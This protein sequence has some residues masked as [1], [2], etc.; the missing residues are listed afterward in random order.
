MIPFLGM[1]A[2]QFAVSIMGCMETGNKAK[3]SGDDGTTLYKQVRNRLL[4]LSFYTNHHKFLP[5]STVLD[6]TVVVDNPSPTD[7]LAVM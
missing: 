6:M 3:D 4:W 2:L 5:S 1:G 7:V